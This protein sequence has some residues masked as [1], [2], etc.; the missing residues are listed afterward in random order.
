MLKT[1]TNPIWRADFPD[2]FIL[3]YKQK[4]YAYAT[5]T[6]ERG[7][8]FQVMESTDLVHLAT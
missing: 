4:F 1:Y 7:S 3:A 2:P 8:G 5:E 6:A